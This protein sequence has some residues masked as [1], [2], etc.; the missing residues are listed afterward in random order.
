MG[1]KGKSEYINKRLVEDWTSMMNWLQ[2]RHL[3][4]RTEW[5]NRCHEM[6]SHEMAEHQ[7][8]SNAINDMKDRMCQLMNEWPDLDTHRKYKN[9]SS[10]MT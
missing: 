9:S 8:Y 6:D 4:Y 10:T 5:D 3:D 1:S 7:G 2:S